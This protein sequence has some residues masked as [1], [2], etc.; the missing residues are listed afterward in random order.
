MVQPINKVGVL[1]IQLSPKDPAFEPWSCRPSLQHRIYGATLQM[2]TIAVWAE[3]KMCER[4]PRHPSVVHPW[5]TGRLLCIGTALSRDTGKR[6]LHFPS[7][8]CPQPP[9]KLT[10]EQTCALNLL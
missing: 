5:L 2:Q 1:V 4:L 7:L 3:G 8:F 10:L 6:C 9:L